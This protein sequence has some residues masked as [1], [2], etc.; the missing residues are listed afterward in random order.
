MNSTMTVLKIM[1]GRK[2]E[3]TVIPRTLD[4]MQKLVCGYI[5]AIYP[6]EDNVA[7]VCNEEGKLIG[8]EPNR[9]VYDPDTGDIL[10]IISGTFF[11]C[12]LGKEDFCSLT[13]QQLDYYS[14]LFC[15]PEM[16]L[17]NGNNLVIVEMD[18][19]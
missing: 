9:A 10:D 5:Q 14:N 13:D 2:P 1:P 12:G 16:F 19:D 15:N 7:L 17:W 4:A 18:L 8:M 6:Y 3:R 11:V